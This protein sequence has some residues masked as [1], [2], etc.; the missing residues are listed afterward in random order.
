MGKAKGVSSV[1]PNNINFKELL[2]LSNSLIQ[3]VQANNVIN[4][5][6]R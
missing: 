6:L 4:Y 3:I 2:T 1:Y 5:L